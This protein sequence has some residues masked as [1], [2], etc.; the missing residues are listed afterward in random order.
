MKMKRALKIWLKQC[1]W[2]FSWGSVDRGTEGIGKHLGYVQLDFHAMQK[3]FY[4]LFKVR[5]GN[6]LI[7]NLNESIIPFLGIL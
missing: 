5:Q 7:L 6:W 1:F 2:L 4:K 3:K